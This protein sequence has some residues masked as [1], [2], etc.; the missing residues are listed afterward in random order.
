ML[1]TDGDDDVPGSHGDTDNDE[2]LTFGP[3]ADTAERQ[4]IVATIR[5]YYAAAV[6][7]DGVRACSMLFAPIAEA[8]VEERGQTMGSPSPRGEVCAQVLSK[9]F[10]QHRRELVEDVRLIDVSEIQVKGNRGMARVRF[11]ATRERLERLQRERGVW[12]MS[13]LLDDGSP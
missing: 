3:A 13:V 1:D 10:K 7:G 12:E 2:F 6:A 9:L 11:G 8:V 5:R 4:V